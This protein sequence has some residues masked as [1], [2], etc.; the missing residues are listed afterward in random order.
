MKQKHVRRIDLMFIRLAVLALIMGLYS[1]TNT[2]E[3]RA[4]HR[5]EC[6]DGYVIDRKLCKNKIP[7]LEKMS[8][9]VLAAHFKTIESMCRF[10][11][12]EDFGKIPL[13][14]KKRLA[15]KINAKSPYIKALF[16]HEALINNGARD[17]LPIT[18]TYEDT[19]VHPR[20]ARY[21]Y[22]D[23]SLNLTPEVNDAIISKAIEDYEY[24]SFFS[25]IT[26][27]CCERLFTIHGKTHTIASWDTN[28]GAL[29][30]RWATSLEPYNV[31]VKNNR[32]ASLLVHYRDHETQKPII[33]NHIGYGD[34]NDNGIFKRIAIF[35][36]GDTVSN[37][38]FDTTGDYLICGSN[39]GALIV[40][41]IE[42]DSFLAWV[43]QLSTAG[44]TAL[45]AAQGLL[46]ASGCQE[47]SIRLWNP[48]KNLNCMLKGH[49]RAIRSVNFNKAGDLL[50]SC[51]EDHTVRLWSALLAQCLH[52]IKTT[53]YPIIDTA[54]EQYPF[55]NG[56]NR[57]DLWGCHFENEDSAMEIGVIHS[58]TFDGQHHGRTL[59]KHA[60]INK[61]TQEDLSNL[62]LEQLCVLQQV[63]DQILKNKAIDFVD[64]KKLQELYVKFPDRLKAVIKKY[65]N[66]SDWMWMNYEDT[67]ARLLPA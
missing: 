46:V 3:S 50:L 31:Q 2:M 16:L 15:E 24:D 52:T 48:L 58:L 53:N 13:Q 35:Y 33:G 34:I 43:P 29:V 59:L 54:F 5:H 21:L 45:A 40:W 65:S 14:F 38:I 63:G 61:K 25:Y 20:P 39:N 28:T 19:Y 32:I 36:C 55:V 44:I 8:F 66:R 27:P 11:K 7:S 56:T 6:R 42:A 12:K 60:F 1:F 26:Q 41:D 9:R 17:S 64:K 23:K 67:K 22:L 30:H 18:T 37:F 10:T 51:S 49:T 57:E 62:S 47:G 4:I